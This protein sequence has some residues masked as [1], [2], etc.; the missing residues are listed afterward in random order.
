M[1]QHCR[2]P[3]FYLDLTLPP[4]IFILLILLILHGFPS[5]LQWGQHYVR[6]YQGSHELHLQN[7]LKYNIIFLIVNQTHLYA[8]IILSLKKSTYNNILL[9]QYAHCCFSLKVTLKS[10]KPELVFHLISYYLWISQYC[11]QKSYKGWQWYF[12]SFYHSFTS[13]VMS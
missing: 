1:Q 5:K 11:Q 2:A 8:T 6:L 10:S 13:Y 12:G 4:L 7:L 9:L 3:C